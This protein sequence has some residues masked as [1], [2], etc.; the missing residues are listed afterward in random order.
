[1]GYGTAPGHPIDLASQKFKEIVEKKSNGR[2]EVRLF[3]SAQLGSERQLIEGLK[4]GTVEMTPTTTGPMGLFDPQ[5][6][7]FD[8]PYIFKDNKAA[9]KVLDGPIGQEMLARMDRIGMVGLAWWENGFREIT[10]N[11]RPIVKPEDLKGIKL[12]TM[13]NEVHMK[14]FKQLGATP[15]PL[16]FGE[17]YMACKS[18]TVDGQENPTS[19]IATNK[20]YEVQKYMTK[21]DHVYSPVIVLISKKFWDQLPSD[22]QKLIKDTAL[23]VREYERNEGRQ[24]EKEY[25]DTI[26]KGGTQY[27]ELTDE[28][29]ALWRAEAEKMYPDFEQKIGKELLDKVRKAG[30]EE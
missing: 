10:N 1:M 26:K 22:L 16:G 21:T 20:F 14:Y 12:R 28:Q 13:E 4:A 24:K 18:K 11:V 17:I 3:P 19:I 30:W 7:V 25:I 29:K 5:F 6:L 9:D 2:I 23:E 15:V 27:I 8:L